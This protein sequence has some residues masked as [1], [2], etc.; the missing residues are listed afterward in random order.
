[1]AVPIQPRHE[2]DQRLLIGLRAR[3]LAHDAPSRNTSMRVDSAMSSGSSLEMTSTPVPS[4]AS[5]PI[6]A[7]ISAFAPTSTPRV[8]S[9]RIRIAAARRQ[10]L[11]EHDLLL[12]A[13]RQT[14]ASARRGSAAR[15]RS[16]VEVLVAPSRAPR[17]AGSNRSRASVGSIGS[18]MLCSAAHRQHEPLSLAIL[19]HEAD[20]QR[21]IAASASRARSGPPRDHRPAPSRRVQAEERLRDLGSAGAH[22]PREADHL[23]RAQRERDV[24]ELAAGCVSSFDAQ[25]LRRPARCARACGKYS[26]SRRPIIICTSCRLGRAPP[27]AAWRRAARRAAR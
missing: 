22:Q 20:A 14:G 6:S 9:S 3:E 12:V 27:P 13:A 19:G 26:S 10:P 5:S 21:C 4:A 17:A 11:G 18:D 8:G 15:T 7:W 2:P 23:A 24:L 1:M 25:Q 16:R